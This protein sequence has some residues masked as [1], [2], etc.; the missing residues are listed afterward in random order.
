M[1]G[2]DRGTTNLPRFEWVVAVGGSQVRRRVRS[3][4]QT[5]IVHFLLQRGSDRRCW[6]K[7]DLEQRS[8]HVAVGTITF[9]FVVNLGT[10]VLVLDAGTGNEIRA[11]DPLCKRGHLQYMITIT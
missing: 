2:I 8:I 5:S 1:N 7:E 11:V 10:T 9:Q 3:R 4:H 6:R